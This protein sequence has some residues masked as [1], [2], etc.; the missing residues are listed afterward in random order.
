MADLTV[1]TVF[2]KEGDCFGHS[3]LLSDNVVQDFSPANKSSRPEGLHYA[4]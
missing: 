2:S 3:F 4:F 1:C